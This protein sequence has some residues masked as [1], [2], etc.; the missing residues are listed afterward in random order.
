MWPGNTADVKSLI[1]VV[2]RMK[3]SFAIGRFCI[4]SD[5]GMISKETMTYLEKEHILYILGARMGNVKEIKEE[6]R[7]DGKWVLKTNTDLNAEQVALKYK[8]L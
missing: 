5:R 4:V 3:N 2:E 6:E 8:E 1:P 7:F